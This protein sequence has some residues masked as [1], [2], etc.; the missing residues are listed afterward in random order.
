[1]IE[2]IIGVVIG[3]IISV[4]IAEIYHRRSSASLRAEIQRLESANDTTNQSIEDMGEL[5][6][7]IGNDVEMTKRHT[8]SGTSNDP[9]YPYK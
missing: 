7:K 5:A 2:L 4:T 6:S 3:A 8:V 9:R 1:M